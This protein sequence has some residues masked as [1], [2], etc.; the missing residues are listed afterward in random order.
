MDPEGKIALDIDPRQQLLG[1]GQGRGPARGHQVVGPLPVLAPEPLR[2]AHGARLMLYALREGFGRLRRNFGLVFVVLASNLG[3]AALLAVPLA[4]PPRGRPR[5]P[6]RR[7]REP[8]RLRHLLA[9]RLEGRPVGLRPRLRPRDLRRGLRL[10]EP[11]A[12]PQGPAARGPLRRGPKEG[13]RGRRWTP[14]SSAWGS[15]TSCSRPSWPAGSSRVFRAERGGWTMRGLLHGSGF[16][17]G[18]LLR[19]ALVALALAWLCF[20]LNAPFARFADHMAREAVS[21][22]TALA[23]AFG[24]HLLLLLA[25][26]LAE[27]PLELREGDRGD[28]RA[29]ERAP[30]LG[31]RAWASACAAPP[32]SSATTSW[33]SSSG[34]LAV[35]LWSRLD[36]L[37]RDHGLLDAAPGPRPHAGPAWS[38][39]SPCAWACWPARPPS[40]DE[41]P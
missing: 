9:R 6:R 7:L 35:A 25:L 13:P 39:A 12:A 30:R 34:S 40:T 5:E 10:P 14:W 16:Y 2:A 8:L 15:S 11:R 41:G 36:G 17:F 32:P 3:L 18:R 23:W 26:L 4:E 27:P 31:L 21:E 19:V 24:R 33:S 37:V 1:G 20:R 22:T 38:P 28:R 29:L